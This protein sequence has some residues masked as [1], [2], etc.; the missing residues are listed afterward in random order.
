MAGCRK[1]NTARQTTQTCCRPNCNVAVAHS[2]LSICSTFLQMTSS[3]KTRRCSRSAS[4]TT[5]TRRNART[6]TQ[7]VR[8]HIHHLQMPH[9]WLLKHRICCIVPAYC[10]C[11][12]VFV[13]PLTLQLV[14]I[15]FVPPLR[16]ELRRQS[17]LLSRLENQERVGHCMRMCVCVDFL[18]CSVTGCVSLFWHCNVQQQ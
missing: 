15:Y 4:I 11:C 5:W 6:R 13:P 9:T 7:T 12:A 10:H 1:L 8:P 2:P 17:Q 14:V 3:L 16:E 18:A